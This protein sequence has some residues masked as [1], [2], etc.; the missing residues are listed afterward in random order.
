MYV[1]RHAWAEFLS[2]WPVPLAS[3]LGQSPRRSVNVDKE[4]EGEGGAW[5]GWP[6]GD[7][8]LR[9]DGPGLLDSKE[10]AY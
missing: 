7:E 6:M 8:M 10:G 2:P 9:L 5:D 1:L 4:D 3:P